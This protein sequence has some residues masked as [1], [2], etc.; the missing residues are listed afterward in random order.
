VEEPKLVAVVDP[1]EYLPGSIAVGPIPGFAA[2]EPKPPG[3][4]KSGLEYPDDGER[5]AKGLLAGGAE[6]PVALP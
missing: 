5:P 4:G 6:K 1:G 2:A 3:G